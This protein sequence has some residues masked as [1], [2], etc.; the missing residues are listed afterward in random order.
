M[1][2][3]L[4]HSLLFPS[5]IVL[6]TVSS[7]PPLF[8]LC[9]PCLS[10]SLSIC[11]SFPFIIHDL[12]VHFY[13]FLNYVFF[14]SPCRIHS[15]IS[16]TSCYLFCLLPPFLPPSC[17]CYSVSSSSFSSFCCKRETLHLLHPSQFIVFICFLYFFPFFVCCHLSPLSFDISASASLFFRHCFS[18]SQRFPLISIATSHN[19][20]ILLFPFPLQLSVSPL[21][22]H[23]SP[24]PLLPTS[25]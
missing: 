13:L 2:Y 4:I 21:A 25:S 5:R 16:F 12:Y 15:F 22:L 19:C 20:C 7:F 10:S 18:L 1:K 6:Y 9:P 17:P 3:S 24:S 14:F 11:F 23:T 8:P